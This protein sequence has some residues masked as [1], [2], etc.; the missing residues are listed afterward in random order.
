MAMITGAIN[1]M[2]DR[3]VP[4]WKATNLHQSATTQNSIIVIA[5]AAIEKRA[6]KNAPPSV[7]VSRVQ[8]HLDTRKY[9]M[10]C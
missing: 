1:V 6:T 8:Q 9:F 2:A 3:T 5:L 10:V 4:I 7:Y